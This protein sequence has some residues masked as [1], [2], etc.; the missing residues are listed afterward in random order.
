[1]ISL[2]NE[3]I[4]IVVENFVNALAHVHGTMNTLLK[5]PERGSETLSNFAI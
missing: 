3:I 5:I 4:V 2:D 1:M